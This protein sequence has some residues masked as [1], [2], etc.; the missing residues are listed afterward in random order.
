MQQTSAG[1]ALFPEEPSR[2]TQSS[3]DKL[4]IHCSKLDASDITIQT[5]QP[6][7]AE[8]HGRLLP[9]TKYQTQRPLT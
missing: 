9:I 1:D 8:I 6:I 7:V 3:I 2:F 5:D 4:L